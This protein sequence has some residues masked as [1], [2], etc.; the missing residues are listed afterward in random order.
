MKKIIIV[1]PYPFDSA[2][3]QRLHYEQY[4]E[5]LNSNGYSFYVFSFFSTRAYSYIY[6]RKLFLG[7][8]L[9]VFEGLLRRLALAF[10]LP[11]AD[12]VYIHLNVVPI[13]PCFFERL[14]ILL[15]K[16]VI[17]DINDMVHL[18]KTS[19]VNKIA[20]R[21]KSAE[22]YYLL[23]RKCQHVITCTPYLEKIAREYNSSVTT[24]FTTIN[25]D[26]LVPV[27]RLHRG[28]QLAIGWSGSHS[29]VPYLNIL[30]GV[31]KSL[32]QKYEF[33]LIVMGPDYFEMEGVETEV[34]PWSLDVEVSVFARMDIGLYP[35]PDDEWVKGKGGGKALQ[36]MSCGL[37]VV[38]TLA[39]CNADL[40][41]D[42]VSGLLA[43]SIDD[44]Y[45]LLQALI[46]DADLRSRLGRAARA[47][48]EKIYSVDAN[49]GTYLSIFQ[50]VYGPAR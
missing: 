2:P 28:G 18:K 23:M 25:T 35:L 26:R 8:I 11:F 27:S 49:K 39:G 24:V 7:K 21:L 30:D 16:T 4:L 33:T 36:Y 44:W 12:G 47:R 34:F 13:G 43:K 41:E 40:I 20:D 29:T 38:A 6:T 22:R 14:Y 50:E 3:S 15:S 19:E 48:V 32:A 42:G 37:P 46:V 1:S 9:F 10:L 45:F 5:F 31:L 17:Y